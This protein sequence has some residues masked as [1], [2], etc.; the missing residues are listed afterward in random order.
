MFSIVAF[1]GRSP[2]ICR[3]V[4]LMQ[5]YPRGR[6]LWAASGAALVPMY[7]L[8]NQGYSPFP[9]KRLVCCFNL[10]LLVRCLFGTNLLQQ[11]FLFHYSSIPLTWNKQKDKTTN[12]KLRNLICCRDWFIYSALFDPPFLSTLSFMWQSLN[13]ILKGVA[14]LSFT[15]FLCIFI[16]AW[17]TFFPSL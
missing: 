11:D 12:R 5:H 9:L 16:S 15:K 4:S 6:V 8:V 10:L 1:D 7:W 2:C 3:M 13:F 17:N 14:L